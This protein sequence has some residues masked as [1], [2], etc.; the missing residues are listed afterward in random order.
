MIDI[1]IIDNHSCLKCGDSNRSM[2]IVGAFTMCITCTKVEFGT[3]GNGMLKKNVED[4]N[5]YK[6][7]LNKYK[8]L[9]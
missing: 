9:V 2:V 4:M 6:F 7:W 5:K 1:R 8:D 3:D